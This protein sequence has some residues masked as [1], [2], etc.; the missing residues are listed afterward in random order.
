MALL[1]FGTDILSTELEEALL[2]APATR[3]DWVII[4]YSVS[5]PEFEALLA[6]LYTKAT[7]VCCRL[8]RQELRTPGSFHRLLMPISF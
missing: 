7:M 4:D 8:K 6:S 3:I 1:L 5:L 2:H